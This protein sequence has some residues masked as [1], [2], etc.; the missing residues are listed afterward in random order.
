MAL[1]SSRKGPRR[2][3]Q[4]EGTDELGM[5]KG[6]RGRTLFVDVPLSIKV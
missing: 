3:L 2:C 4:R 1:T 5:G 6:I